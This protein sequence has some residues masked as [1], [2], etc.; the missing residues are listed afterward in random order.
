M[1]TKIKDVVCGMDVTSESSFHTE[2]EH[3]KYYF[4]SIDCQGKFTNNPEAYIEH[5]H[6]ENCSSCAPLGMLLFLQW[7]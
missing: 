4:C 1:D 7:G 3:K 6:D 5:E 2:H